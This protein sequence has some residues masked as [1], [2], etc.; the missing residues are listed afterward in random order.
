MRII[1]AST[2]AL[3]GC[4][5]AGAATVVIDP[6]TATASAS[7]QPDGGIDPQNLV[8]S[9]GLTSAY[10]TPGSSMAYDSSALPQ[11]ATPDDS[12][13]G[14][15]Y[16]YGYRE[17]GSWSITLTFTLDQSYDL[18]GL[19]DW[20]YQELYP[21]GGNPNS[22]YYNNRGVQQATVYYSIDGGLNYLPGGTVTLLEAP[23]ETSGYT[24][25]TVNFGSELLGVDS[26]ELVTDSNYGGDHLGLNEV[27][28]LGTVAV[29]EPASTGLLFA[30]GGLLLR[31]RRQ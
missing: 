5:S 15:A 4:A 18:T 31:R 10:G 2:L 3:L 8:N 30:A 28:F 13:D 7:P 25:D 17:L 29:P 19:H 11:A 12:V 22:Q 6:S 9:Y 21:G 20:N 1:A 16:A 24:G 14:N 27:R 26:I 23:D